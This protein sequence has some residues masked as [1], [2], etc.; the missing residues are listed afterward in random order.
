MNENENSCCALCKENISFPS[1]TIYGVRL[2]LTCELLLTY[3]PNPDPAPLLITG[4]DYDL[5]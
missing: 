4:V 2:C 3:E 1:L 5:D